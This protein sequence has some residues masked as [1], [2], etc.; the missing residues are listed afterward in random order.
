VELLTSLFSVAQK[1][2]VEHVTSCDKWVLSYAVYL[3]WLA[4]VVLNLI[5][6]SV[7]VNVGQCSEKFN[8]KDAPYIS[9]LDSDEHK[10]TFMSCQ[11]KEEHC[12][13][14]LNWAPGGIYYSC[15]E[16]KLDCKTTG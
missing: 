15:R 10:S 5:P 6:F 4:V 16:T 1:H 2:C 8:V 9:E 14:T 7:G 12:R 13:Y 3:A 11:L